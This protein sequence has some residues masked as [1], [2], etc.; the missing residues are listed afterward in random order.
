M[1]ACQYPLLASSQAPSCGISPNPLSSL[2]T[3]V[4]TLF[5]AQTWRYS[6]AELAVVAED[7]Q[8]LNARQCVDAHGRTVT[9]G[10]LVII[11]GD[12][13]WPRELWSADGALDVQG[14]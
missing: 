7:D 12:F 10:C 3:N 13:A 6:L 8:G 1:W 2:L 14:D 11:L 9:A 4:C 5:E